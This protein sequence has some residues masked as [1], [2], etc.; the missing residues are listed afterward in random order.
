M[1]SNLC[2]PWRG[3]SYHPMQHW[4]RL[5]DEVQGGRKASLGESLKIQGCG[6]MRFGWVAQASWFRLVLHKRDGT[7]MMV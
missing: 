7:P 5:E 6:G 1:K 3:K 4:G 2:S